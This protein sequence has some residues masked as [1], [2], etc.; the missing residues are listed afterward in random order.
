[1]KIIKDNSEKEIKVKCKFCKSKFLIKTKEIKSS[2]FDEKF[3]K[4]PVCG[5]TIWFK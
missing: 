5:K 2:F 3:V 1:M 4:C